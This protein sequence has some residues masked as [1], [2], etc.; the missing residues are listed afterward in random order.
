[1]SNIFD[2][3]IDIDEIKIEED[4]GNGL[5]VSAK[6]ALDGFCRKGVGG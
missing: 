4:V 1:M 5:H 2:A 3:V 6:I